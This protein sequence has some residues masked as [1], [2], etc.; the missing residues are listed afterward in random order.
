TS[1][2]GTAPNG[3]ADLP[4]SS[5]VSRASGGGRAFERAARSSAAET[6]RVPQ[7]VSESR[8]EAQAGQPEPAAPSL[9]LRSS[10][11]SGCE[12]DSFGKAPRTSAAAAETCGA[13]ND[14]PMPSLN[15]AGP[16]LA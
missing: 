2:R 5:F 14:V 3:C 10:T 13:A 4:A 15:S 12:A 16:Q 11:H 9:A 6:S 7:P 1:V 8:P